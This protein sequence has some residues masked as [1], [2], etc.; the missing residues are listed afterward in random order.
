MQIFKTIDEIRKF[1]L[2][3]ILAKKRVGFVATMGALHAGHLKLVQESLEEN[4]KT[5]ISIYVN[6]TQFGENEDL[7]QYPRTFDDDCSK[8]QQLQQLNNND[9]D[10]DNNDNIVVFA[11]SSDMMY[12][13]GIGTENE[14]IKVKP[15]AFANIAEGRI[16][17]DFFNGVSQICTKLFNIVQPDVTY[18]GQKDI[19]QCILIQRL[20][21]DLCMNIKVRIIETIR[22]HDGLAMSSRNIYLNQEERHLSKI[23]YQA[24]LVG[25]HMC[26]DHYPNHSDNK[27]NKNNKNNKK[28]NKNNSGNTGNTGNTGSSN[29]EN[30]KNKVI[31]AVTVIDAVVEALNHPQVTVQYVSLSD[32]RNM[33]EL[34]YYNSNIGAILSAAVVLGSVRLIDN[35]V[36][37]DAARNIIYS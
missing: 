29:D 10:N 21:I 30:G 6:P 3:C 14:L 4:H 9:N 5:I 8:L 25:Q 27:N 34:T 19:S 20:V 22:E 26:N 12:P 11:P 2:E 24:L 31:E 28:N 33:Q 18:F 37:G 17:P 15:E 16:R 1:K 13:N 36:V 35:V 32:P 23:L 7:H